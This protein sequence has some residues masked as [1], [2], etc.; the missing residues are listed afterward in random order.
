MNNL[1]NLYMDTGKKDQVRVYFNKALTIG[2]KRLGV[3]HPL[4]TDVKN[5]LSQL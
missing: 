2:E 3:S 4:V 5:N 1:S